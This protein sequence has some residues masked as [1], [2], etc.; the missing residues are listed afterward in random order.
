MGLL[1]LNALFVLMTEYNLYVHLSSSG[2]NSK[3]Y[4]RVGSDYPSFYTRLYAFL[5]RDVLHSKHRARFLRMTELFLASTYVLFYRLFFPAHTPSTNTLIFYDIVTYLQTLLASFI[6]RLS[7][8]SLNAPPAAI[9]MVIPFTYNILKRHPA[10]MGM[11]HRIPAE[12]DDDMSAGTFP[13]I[14]FLA[15]NRFSFL[16]P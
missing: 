2:A 11:V 5:D 13:D 8:L 6:K 9:V 14:V 16:Y 12:D 10:L 3:D 15:S 7:R 1:A 4:Y